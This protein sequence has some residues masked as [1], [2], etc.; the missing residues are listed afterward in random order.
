MSPNIRVFQKLKLLSKYKCKAGGTGYGQYEVR[1][2]ISG[3][4]RPYFDRM[5]HIFVNTN[6]ISK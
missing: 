6:E 5:Q 2:K 3:E 4:I 1:K